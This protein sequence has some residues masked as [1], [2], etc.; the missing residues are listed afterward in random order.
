MSAITR[1]VF[2]GSAAAAAATTTLGCRAS[3]GAA[4]SPNDVLRVAVVGLR[5][6]GRDH[7]NQFI[8]LPGVEVAA[9]CD[10]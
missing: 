9:L 1:R 2:L 7:V 8:D 4:A 6:R 3:A 10:V 5:G